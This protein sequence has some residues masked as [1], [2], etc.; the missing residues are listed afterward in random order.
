MPSSDIS[1]FS[2]HGDLCGPCDLCDLYDRFDLW[3]LHH[4]RDL[5]DLGDLCDPL[6][7]E[8]HGGFSI[9]GIRVASM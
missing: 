5:C 2:A 8:S 9:W 3:D 4:L 6:F 7:V 1:T